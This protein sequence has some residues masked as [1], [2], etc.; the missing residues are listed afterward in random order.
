VSAV[1][2]PI[3]PEAPPDRGALVALRSPSGIA[4]IAATALASMVG[5]LNAY[6]VNVAVP[7]IGRE[8]GASVAALQWTL[9]GY[10]VTVAAL[11]L[12]S[13]ALADRFG[14]RRVLTAGLLI[15]LVTSIL[16]AV[17]P[18]AGALIG[19]RLAQG[20]G[21]ALVVPS[22]LALLNGTLRVSDRAR[23]IGIWAALATL[24]TTAGPYAGGWLVDHASWR[25]IFLLN[26][27]LIA[28]ALLALRCVPE[29]N[30]TP[31]A[32]SA[33][34]LGGL[35]AVA[36]L[37]GL[38]YALTD[39]PAH[40]WLSARVL[41][42]GAGG[43]VAMAALLPVERRLRAPMLRLS[44]FKS[45]QFDAINATTVLFYGALSAASYLLVLQCEL[46]LGYSGSQAGAALIPQAAVF[47][48]VSP[49]SGA[50][51]PHFGPRRLMACG[52]LAVGAAFAWLSTALPGTSYAD[53]ILP[54]ALLSGLGMGL[55]VTPL[56]A[57]V[58]AAVADPDLGEASA[59]NDAASRLGG[60][61]AIALVPALIGAGGGRSLAGALAHG[62]QPAMIALAA[63]CA[64][65]AAVTAVFVADDRTEAPRLAAPAPHHGSALPLRRRH[66]D[67]S[68]HRVVVVGG[69][70]GGLLTARHL[71]SAPV[72]L[73]LVDRRNFHLFQPLT[74]QV[75]TG[76][77]EAGDVA[78]PL[79]AIFKRHRNVRVLMAEVT[80][81]DLDARQV[82]LGSD[83]LAYD[84]L[85][86]AGGSQYS[87]FGHDEWRPLAPEVKSLESALEMRRRIL[88]AFEAAEVEP[89]PEVRR[90][91]LT[92]VV[93]GAGPTGVETA[94][95]I[96]ELARDTLRRDFRAIDPRECRVLLVEQ[97][98][99]VL[100]AFPPS[101][102]ERARRSLQSLGVTPVLE[103]TVI[104]IDA[105]AVTVGARRGGSERIPARTVIWA[106]GVEASE[107]AAQ[108]GEQSGAD[109]DRAGRVTVQPDLTLPG[110]PEVLA[111]GDMV[112]VRDAHG[113]VQALPGL[114]PV[115]MQQGRYAAR[116]VRARLRGQTV[117]PFRYRD[118]GNLATIG[119]ARAVADLHVLR[120]S[121][122]LAWVTWLVV[123]L[124]YLVGFQNRVLVF[125]QWAF[126][127]LT[128]GRGARL[129]TGGDE[130]A[131]AALDA[132]SATASLADKAAR[133]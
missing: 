81:F 131:A 30:G 29:T 62:Y 52:I 22:S 31:R 57:G 108:L 59:I 18:S 130:E 71:A 46:R 40:G 9:T 86:V 110:H 69:G 76:A 43:L 88:G 121:G 96:A 4:V 56:T 113:G 66:P 42:A 64:A 84:T 80:G 8:F 32:L 85:I 100:T 72:E 117:A 11:L 114:A 47:L 87:Y 91:L 27:P 15:M 39:G 45:R 37:G 25:W 118:K 63:L 58:L 16:C 93:V 104:H 95:Q 129:I 2:V 116:L 20:A 6:V 41:V 35:L 13:G 65:A 128:R 12:L 74:Y 109:V 122:F 102:S 132:D 36:G 112:R 99:R 120:L 123:H 17:A 38:I 92:F 19:A 10:L 89:D 111:L 67:A 34:V 94:G 54:S 105:D 101:L 51:V 133:R 5:F 127:F 26:V 14:R 50:L 98:D 1:A 83:A 44:L 53:T 7:A 75:A 125:I 79:R 61:V 97:A 107:L 78:Y 82:R 55:A 68:T 49:L 115:A 70:F 24:G 119:R 3:T 33:D 21:G 23:A 124:W 60:V 48:A 28:G 126:S 77:L 106:A 73:T 90:A 103:R